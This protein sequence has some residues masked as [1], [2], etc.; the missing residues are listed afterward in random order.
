MLIVALQD[1][2]DSLFAIWDTVCD[3]FLG[4]NLSQEESIKIIMDKKV[5]TYE[6]ARSRTECPQPFHDL[7]RA[8]STYNEENVVQFLEAEIVQAGLRKNKGPIYDGVNVGIAQ[9][10]QLQDNHIRFCQQVIKL[11]KH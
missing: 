4:V 10:N 5:C 3:R 9:A 11:L 8:V 1:D 2:V 7:A 6:N